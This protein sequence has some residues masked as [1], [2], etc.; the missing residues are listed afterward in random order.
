MT[1][2]M[3]A[4][5]LHGREDVRIEDVEI[6]RLEPGDVL[7]KT[8]VALTCG[9]DVKVFRRGYHA[10]MLAPPALFG[11]EVAGTVAEVGPGPHAIERGAPVVAANSA[12]CG[13]CEYCRR[14]RET[15]CDDLQFWNGAYA[16]FVR[17]P[18]RVARRNLLRLPEGLGF[19]EAALTEP[20]ACVVRGVEETLIASG[21][22][23]AVIGVGP[24]GLMLAAIARRGGARVVAFGRRPDR[25]LLARDMGA[26]ATVAL[27]PGEDLAAA[28]RAESP[29]GR[30]PHV[31]FEAAGAVETAE[32]AIRGVRKGGI[33]NL[34]A[35]CPAD[36]HLSVDAQR[37]HY[38]EITITSSFHHTPTTIREALRLI[39]ARAVDANALISADAGLAD[40]PAVLRGALG[41]G[42]KTAIR[43]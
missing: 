5:V 22:T 32:A 11:H 6:P 14:G 24:V 33:V 42:L 29:D 7:L 25:L 3:R 30:G 28:L 35:G 1:G 36:S 37:L 10:R 23:V 4:A 40:L 9:T 34:F 31:V 2:S 21:D 41:G 16:E 12:P 20:L 13:D 15:L 39:A 27:K 19:R 17:I 26:A 38:D 18:A 8:E 43:P